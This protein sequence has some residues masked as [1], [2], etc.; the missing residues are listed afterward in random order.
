MEGLIQYTEDPIQCMEDKIQYMADQMP[1]MEDQIQCI[2]GRNQS[3]VDRIQCMVDRNHYLEG[4]TEDQIQCQ[5]DL[6]LGVLLVTS[7]AQIRAKLSLM[8]RI[9]LIINR[10]LKLTRMDNRYEQR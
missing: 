5:V 2:V 1:C 3:I 7:G 9:I 6:I 10:N 8:C 4:L